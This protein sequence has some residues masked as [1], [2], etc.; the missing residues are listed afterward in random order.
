MT[1]IKYDKLYFYKIDFDTG[2][3][4]EHELKYRKMYVSGRYVATSEDCEIIGTI[5][6]EDINSN[7]PTDI[8]K[9]SG[10]IPPLVGYI[11]SDKREIEDVSSLVRDN[12]EKEFRSKM[13][14]FEQEKFKYKSAMRLFHKKK[15]R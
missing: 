2:E 3:I 15:V 12:V 6:H 14:E 1:D 13:K 5:N 7:K 8:G 11:W 10:K 4:T 9:A